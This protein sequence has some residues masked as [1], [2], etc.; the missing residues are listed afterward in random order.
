M[1]IFSD[2]S[3][4]KRAKAARDRHAEK[5]LK[6]RGSGSLLSW[7]GSGRAETKPGLFGLGSRAVKDA[8]QEN[9]KSGYYGF[10]GAK[11]VSGK[12]QRA[13]ERAREKKGGSWFS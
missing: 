8:E 11:H 10:F 9:A 3:A 12:A 13:Q 6:N 1:G 7:G 4:A 5:V 2:D